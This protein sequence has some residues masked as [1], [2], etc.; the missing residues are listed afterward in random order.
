MLKLTTSLK[1]RIPA[2]IWYAQTLKPLAIRHNIQVWGRYETKTQGANGQQLT[3]AHI[4]VRG[5]D[6]DVAAF[7]AE[8]KKI[9]AAQV[10]K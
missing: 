6:H 8:A 2:F 10:A 1:T 4:G 7:M 5:A 9:V 3:W